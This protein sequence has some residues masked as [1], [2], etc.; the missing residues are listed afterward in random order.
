MEE[1]LEYRAYVDVGG[2]IVTKFSKTKW[3]PN[4]RY[5]RCE[6]AASKKVFLFALL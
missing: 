1:F 4:R 3:N 5:Y 2:K 6:V